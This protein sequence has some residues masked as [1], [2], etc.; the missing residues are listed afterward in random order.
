MDV[1]KLQWCPPCK[2]VTRHAM[3]IVGLP[4]ICLNEHT[5]DAIACASCGQEFQPN[6]SRLNVVLDLTDPQS[7]HKLLCLACSLSKA[8]NP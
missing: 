7:P 2:A 1:L 3:P 5:N 8:P 4:Y 6:V